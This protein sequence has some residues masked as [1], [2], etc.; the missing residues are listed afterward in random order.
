[1]KI[2]ILIKEY[3]KLIKSDE[4]FA[5]SGMIN[6]Y[7]KLDYGFFPLGS[8][9]LTEN[10]KI[11]IA[12]IEEGGTMV[13]GN[14]FGTMSYVE[15]EC[16]ETNR[17]DNSKTITILKDIGLDMNETFFTNFYLGLRNDID[18]IG[19]SNTKRIKK[20]E[21]KY[22]DLCFDF[23]LVQLKLIN[24]KRIVCL[25]TYVGRTLSEYSDV[26]SRFS[27]KKKGITKLFENNTEQEYIVETDDDIFKRRKFI[28]I[29]HPSFAHINWG[30]NDIRNKIKRALRD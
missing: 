14:D 26:F 6:L 15:N 28:L 13:L 30:K 3:E 12:E 16:F 11:K 5:N 7:A 24:P 18:H 8:G 19:T 29:P 4:V 23:F 25:G 20:I 27:M 22:K 2:E 17:E 1:M 21:Q 9:I 10:S